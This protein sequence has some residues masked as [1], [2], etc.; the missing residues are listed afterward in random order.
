MISESGPWKARLIRDSSALRK[1][2]EQY[3]V[4]KSREADLSESFLFQI[5]TFAFTT[6]FVVRKLKDSNKLSDE[7]ESTPIK[8]TVYRR[9]KIRKPHI[10]EDLHPINKDYTF[11]APTLRDISLKSLCD[12]II[13]SHEFLI[14]LD[15]KFRIL[16][17][18]NS[19]RTR[20]ELFEVSLESYVSLIEAVAEDDVVYAEMERGGKWNELI[21]VK[22]SRKHPR[23]NSDTTFPR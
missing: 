16:L 20:S 15:D 17:T 8:M 18:F 14:G 3:R 22:K 12:C 19:D 21:V 7:L 9:R 6:A 5:E 2:I 11:R 13:H 10:D 4:R 23:R 1:R